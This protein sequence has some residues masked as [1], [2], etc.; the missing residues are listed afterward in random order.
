ML[1][2]SDWQQG[3]DQITC[4]AQE[5]GD[6]CRYGRHLLAVTGSSDGRVFGI[7]PPIKWYR[8]ALEDRHKDVKG[9]EESNENQQDPDGNA[10]PSVVDAQAEQE[11]AD[12]ELDH[13]R[14]DDVSDLA[15]PLEDQGLGPLILRD[16]FDVRSKAM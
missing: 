2:E 1:D 14:D 10:L 5:D 9:V 7:T 8:L 16:M 6:V 4:Y 3:Q 15:C 11:N 13:G 12:D